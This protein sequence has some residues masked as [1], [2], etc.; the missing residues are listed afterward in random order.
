MYPTFLV[1][2]LT[3]CHLHGQFETRHQGHYVYKWMKWMKAISQSTTRSFCT[4]T[5]STFMTASSCSEY[6]YPAICTSHRKSHSTFTGSG[7]S[8]KW[9]TE[10]CDWK[11]FLKNLA[12]RVF[13]CV[14]TQ[15]DTY[16]D[17]SRTIFFY[18]IKF[19]YRINMP[20]SYCTQI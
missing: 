5:Q 13:L 1:S 3:Q 17:L 18:K 20:S 7:E 15:N 6:R 8:Q 12:L 14:E 11:T 16:S 10:V 2:I 9:I 19:S 4:L